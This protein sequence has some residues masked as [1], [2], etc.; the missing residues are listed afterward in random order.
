MR[1]QE[2]EMRG[3]RREMGEEGAGEGKG[4]ENWQKKGGREKRK[5]LLAPLP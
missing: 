4:E 3:W 1:G 2:G 5:I